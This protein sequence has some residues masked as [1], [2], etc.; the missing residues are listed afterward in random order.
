LTYKSGEEKTKFIKRKTKMQTEF[1]SKMGL[2][3]DKPKVG[4][5]GTSIN[6]NTARKFFNNPELSSK[7]TGLDEDLIERC[8]AI[9]QALSSGYKINVEKFR[10]FALQIAVDLTR[11]YSWY[12]LSPTVH[13]ILI[14]GPSIIENALVSIGELLEEAAEA[15]NKDIKKFRLQHARKTSREATNE[16]LLNRLLLSSDP[17]ITGHRKLPPKTKSLLNKYV[18]DL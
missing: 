4:G 9:L 2:I 12:Y 13:K 1:R 5:C 14:H 6:G 15:R 3:V 17:F 16:D 18:F 10:T 11:T 7:I 8:A